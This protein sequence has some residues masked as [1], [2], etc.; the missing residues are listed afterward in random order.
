MKRKLLN[1]ICSSLLA[2]L[3]DPVFLAQVYQTLLCTKI[4]KR[5]H[6]IMWCVCYWHYLRTAINLVDQVI[7]FLALALN[8]TA[9]LNLQLAVIFKTFSWG[10]P[11]L[12][13]RLF[14]DMIAISKMLVGLGLNVRAR[15]HVRTHW[16]THQGG[17]FRFRPPRLARRNKHVSVHSGNYLW[18]LI[19]LQ[20]R[21]ICSIWQFASRL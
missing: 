4:Q 12:L 2:N 17:Y 8:W 5:E 21:R 11:A 19:V 6:V 15:N 16:V 10:T 13:R 9:L 18:S 7:A 1:L 3:L 14:V 20:P